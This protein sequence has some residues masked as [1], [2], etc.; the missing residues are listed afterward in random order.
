[1][2]TSHEGAEDPSLAWMAHASVA[3]AA[4]GCALVLVFVG[5]QIQ[6]WRIKRRLSVLDGATGGDVDLTG[7]GH[8]HRG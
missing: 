6:R 2:E 3:V 7:V 5:A 8:G 1:M 4:L